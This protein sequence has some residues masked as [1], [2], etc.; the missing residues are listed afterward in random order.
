MS[1]SPTK[2]RRP[3]TVRELE[4]KRGRKLKRK[5]SKPGVR[6]AYVDDEELWSGG[7]YIAENRSH[8]TKHV[9]AHFKK[10][11]RTPRVVDALYREGVAIASEFKELVAEAVRRKGWNEGV[12]ARVTECVILAYEIGAELRDHV[13]RGAGDKPPSPPP[14]ALWR[15]WREVR[16]VTRDER[17]GML[18]EQA[19]LIGWKRNKRPLGGAPKKTIG[20]ALLDVM[21]RTPP[22]TDEGKLFPR[23]DVSIY[24][25][26]D[27]VAFHR[28]IKR[29]KD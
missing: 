9:V 12:A 29:C 26:A 14:E 17:A 23:K 24:Y 21:Q 1:K 27:R 3:M 16:A 10:V 13:G 4:Q 25:R 8:E 28:F 11:L 15:P 5:P 18:V 6:F 19:F 22:V 2:K 7:D 20:A